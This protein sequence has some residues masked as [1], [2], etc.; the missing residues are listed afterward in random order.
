MTLSITTTMDIYNG[1]QCNK[2]PQK[3]YFFLVTYAATVNSNCLKKLLNRVA[4][5]EP[6]I[7]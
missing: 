2:K 4:L 6:I 7:D 5:N 1:A 3:V